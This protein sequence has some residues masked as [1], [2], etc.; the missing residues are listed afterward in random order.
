MSATVT[1]DWK[2]VSQCKVLVLLVHLLLTEIENMDEDKS[3]T[4]K[5]KV[6][7]YV[8]SFAFRG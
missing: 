6:L 5:F 3:I 4:I 8:Y 1:G 2:D 7:A